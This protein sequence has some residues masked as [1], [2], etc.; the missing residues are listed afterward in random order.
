MIAP[1]ANRPRGRVVA[2]LGA[3][4]TGKTSTALALAHRIAGEPG[5]TRADVGLVSESL[6]EWGDR[7]GRTPERDE[8]WGIAA[9]QTRRIAEA[10]SRHRLVI[11]DTSSAMTA[12]YSRFVFGD[13]S[14]DRPA[15]ADHV[16][17]VDLTLV[18]AL[19]LPWTPDGLQRD[20]PH[21][22]EPVDRLLRA[23]LRDADIAHAVVHG[24]GPARLHAALRALLP[25]A[26][27]WGFE[28]PRA[29]AEVVA[30]LVPKPAGAAGDSDTG[31]DRN[32][33][34]DGETDPGVD[35]RPTRWTAWCACCSDPDGEAADL[36]ALRLRHPR[37]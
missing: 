23:L 7:E 2:L 35:R 31:T 33:A 24:R 25:S 20:G 19:D 14:L 11:A 1:P 16:A 21:V 22:R 27:R 34:A 17:G 4:S 9:E 15:L 29:E 6:R 5:W 26:R 12:V 32:A 3:E 8:Q 18:T 37:P 13:R 28:W 30:G 10:A 36:R